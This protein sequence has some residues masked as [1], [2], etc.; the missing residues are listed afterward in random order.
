MS[1]FKLYEIDSMLREALDAAMETVNPE[2]GE[3]PE[4][5]SEFLETVQMERDAKALAVAAVIKEKEAEADA[6]TV[7]LKK[8]RA[9]ATAG[10]NAAD[11]LRYYL[12]LFMTEGEK[13]KDARVS[14]GWRTT[15]AI[16][17]EVPELVP[18]AF[19]RIE[20]IPQKT[21]IKAEIEAGREVPGAKQVSNTSIQIR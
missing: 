21:A 18:D 6:I 1:N 16:E 4:G 14:I 9:R 12:R 15:K 8:L 10:N 19:C 11:R 5:W 7:E 2:T 20:R 17:I 13:L 3:L